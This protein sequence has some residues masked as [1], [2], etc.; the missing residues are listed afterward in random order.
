M[1]ALPSQRRPSRPR[2]R[3]SSRSTR[4]WC[5]ASCRRR[6]ADWLPLW[7]YPFVALAFLTPATVGL[8]IA[9]RSRATGSRGS[10]SSV[11]S[12]RRSSCRSRFCSARDGRS[13]S[14]GRSGRSSTRGRSPSRSSSR[15]G[16]CSRP[17]WRWVALGAAVSFAGSSRSRCSTPSRSTATTPRSRTRWRTTPSRDGSG[18]PMRGC[19]SRFCSGM[20]GSLVAGAVAIRHP[21]SPL[22]RHRAAADPVARVGGG[23]GP[24]HALP[25]HLLGAPRPRAGG[26]DRRLGRLPAPAPDRHR[27]RGVSRDR[28]R[29]LPAVRDRASRQPHAR[30]RGP[31]GAARLRVRRAHHRPRRARRRRLGVDHGRRDAR[32]GRRVPAAPPPHPGHRRPALQPRA[33]PGRPPRARVRGRGARRP[34]GARGDRRRA[35]RGARR[36]ARRAA[37]LAPRD[38]RRTRTPRASSSDLP[39]DGRA[40][41]EIDRDGA[42]TAVLLHDP[43]SSSGAT[44]CDG[45]LAAA[46]LSIEMARL[47]VEVRLQLAEVEASRARIV[48][49]GYEE[50]RRLERDL[51]DGAQQRLVSLGVQV[52]RLQRT[53]P[54]GAAIL[55][56]ALDE[57]ST[58]S[59]RRSATSARSPPA[60][61]RRGSTTASRPRSPT[62]RG[63]VADPGRRRRAARARPGERR[64]GRVLRRL[65]GAHERR[66][67][68]LR[69]AGRRCAPSG[70]TAPCSSRVTDDGIGGAVVRRGSGLAG[71]QDR[72][73]AH[74]GTLEV[75][76]PRGGGTRVEVAIPCES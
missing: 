38:A 57:S 37:L 5:S 48:E 68:R 61:G 23:A 69:V 50:R 11:R 63:R 16:G 75:V 4:S 71:L 25:L 21:P 26:H 28:G 42:R 17:R 34:A 60:F 41:T 35:G 45:V 12:G 43:R 56:P 74:G 46:A 54:R 27:R 3:S 13:S 44:C 33:L 30:L 59:G 31:D 2:R 58:R 20:L 62:W 15:T 22:G 24:H 47:R 10:S 9:I 49:A 8:L 53:L 70:R 29:P 36:P 67:A 52:R 18:A 51:H 72:V 65:R 19:R 73:A 40:R 32:G 55:S 6:T 7:F 64:G 66:Q 1:R 14:T 39:D 76:S